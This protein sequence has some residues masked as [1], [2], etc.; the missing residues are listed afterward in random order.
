MPDDTEPRDT[1]QPRQ[2]RIAKGH[3]EA[4]NRVCKAAGITRAEDINTHIR[5]RI[6]AS[7]DPEA[8][9][10][11]EQADAEVAKRRSRMHPG[12]PKKEA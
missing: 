1:T 9:R 5:N 12:R 8:L 6:L 11:L 3:W 2:I 10:L 4:Y 7:D